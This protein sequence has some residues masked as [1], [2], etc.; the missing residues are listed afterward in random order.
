M[1]HRPVILGVV[2]DS[3]AGKT[4]ITSGIA[5]ILGAER[6]T[7]ICIDDYHRYNR[8]QR[9]SLNIS[10]LHPDCNYIDIMEQHLRC[11]ADGQ[12]I[13]KPIYNHHTGDFDPPEYIKP[14]PFV[15]VEG[16]LGFVTSKLR[17]CFHVQVFLDPPED[18]RRTWKIKRDCA[19]RGYNEDQVR[20][21]LVKR[22][23]DS[24]AFIRPQRRWADLVVRFYAPSEPPDSEHLN[25]R[26]T[27]RSTLPH[28]DLTDVIARSNEASDNGRAALRLHVGRDEGRLAEF[29]EIDGQVSAAHA[30]A[31][32]ET[33]WG[34]LPELANLRP[35]QIGRFVEGQDERQSHPLG[36]TQ[37]L[38]AYHLLLARLEKEQLLGR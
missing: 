30:G 22:E 21:E 6:V 12:P 31:I 24:A 18:L 3:G 16:L 29:L 32:E 5:R 36:L 11:L 35:E 14:K 13:L 10:A 17:E 4:T 23:P 26:L 34:H 8:E 2:G 19:K 38:I 27:L 20:A 7:A 1:P 25:V 33:I 15:I 9:K 28:P 37:L